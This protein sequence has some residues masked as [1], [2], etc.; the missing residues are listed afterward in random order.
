MKLAA[1]SWAILALTSLEGNAGWSYYTQPAAEPNRPRAEALWIEGQGSYAT[2]EEL[3]EVARTP[4][5]EHWL[6]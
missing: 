3:L 1:L 5:L 4:D 6:S 2:V